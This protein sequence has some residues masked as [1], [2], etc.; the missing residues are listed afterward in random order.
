MFSFFRSRSSEHYVDGGAVYCP[1]RARDVEVD[2][3][4]GCEFLTRIDLQAKPPLVCC[5]GVARLDYPKT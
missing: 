1:R 2:L 4:T 3:C 5:E